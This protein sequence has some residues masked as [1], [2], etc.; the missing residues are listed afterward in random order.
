MILHG[1][2]GMKSDRP[3]VL[4][5]LKVLIGLAKTCKEDLSEESVGKM[6]YGLQGMSSDNS[7]V[8]EFLKVLT[9][10]MKK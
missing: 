2:Q 6:F 5:L 7:V 8:V 1:M 3:E 9:G 4:E 10:Q